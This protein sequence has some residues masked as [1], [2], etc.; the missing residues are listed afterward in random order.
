MFSCWDIPAQHDLDG[1]GLNLLNSAFLAI[2]ELL[3][4]VVYSLGAN[5]TVCSL[6]FPTINEAT[7]LT[8]RRAD[9]APL[10][11][12][13]RWTTDRCSRI[14]MHTR[15]QCTWRVNVIGAT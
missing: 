7:P 14:D 12:Q 8:A 15:K 10:R 1:Y 5:L 3:F 6:V 13:W 9:G 11:L 4:E 2:S